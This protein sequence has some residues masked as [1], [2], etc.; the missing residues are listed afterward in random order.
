MER[1][2]LTRPGYRHRLID[3]LIPQY[4]AAFGAI[5]IE[6]PKYCGKT[7]TCL[8]HSQ[9]VYYVSDPDNNYANRARARLDPSGILIGEK[10]RL[11]DEWQEAPGIWDAIR[12]SVDQ[13]RDKGGFLITGSSTAC[14]T[15]TTHSGT[16]R[17]ARLSMRPMSLFESG[18]STGTVSLADLINQK[19]ITLQPSRLNLGSLARLLV[20]GGWPE[21]I[22]LSEAAAALIPK[23]YLLSLAQKD[24]SR[25]DGIK[26]DSA[27]ATALLSSIARNT[28][29]IVSNTTIEKD[30]ALNSDGERLS[31]QTI[32]DYLAKLKELFVIEEI[33]GWAPALRSPMRLRLTPKRYFVDPSLA[34]AGLKA[35]TTT[36][37]QDM[38]TFGFLFENLVIRDLLIYTSR[39]GAS[40]STISMTPSWKPTSSSAWEE[41]VGGQSR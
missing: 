1:T 28:A 24:I 27:K 5:L 2:T 41:N 37:L 14:G 39:V 10:P 32:A 21:S 35:D 30:I 19:G 17:I 4:L 16:G 23:Q 12:F 40:C 26:R 6:G 3:E 9:S 29:Q 18:D 7:W 20:R 15:D 33:P 22:D 11:I 31:P 13:G 36:L 38:K 25:L 34:V 8:H